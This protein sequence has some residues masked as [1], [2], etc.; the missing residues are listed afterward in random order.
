M[1]APLARDL[2]Q[3]RDPPI[4]QHLEASERERRPRAVAREA[5]A[6]EIIVGYNA[7]R[8]MNIEPVARRR[9]APLAA[10]KVCVLRRVRR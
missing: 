4:A 3:V 6:A 10:L 2:E 9:E 1:G 8:S 7:D 5:L